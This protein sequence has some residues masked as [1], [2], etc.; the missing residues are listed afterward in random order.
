MSLKSIHL[1]NAWHANSGGIRT[2]YLALLEAAARR[3]HFMRMIVPG[4]E[5]RVEDVSEYGR[6]YYLKTARAPLSPEY[7]MLY[8]PLYL[9]PKG[10]IPRILREERPD[11]IEINDK[12]TLP[13]LSGLIRI[14]KHP[15]IDWRP[16]MIGLSCERMDENMRAYLLKNRAAQAFTRLYMKWIYF[17]E[18]DHHIAVSNHTA[19]EL[20]EASR[21][22]K[23]QRGVWIGP[24]GVDFRLFSDARRTVAA[25]DTVTLL[26]AGRLAR[27]KNL[28]LLIEV[29]ERLP[30]NYRLRIAGAGD[31][32]DELAAAAEARVPGRVSFLG[33]IADRG[34][35]AELYANAD[36]FVHPNP[37]EPFGIAPLEAMAAG[38]PLVAPNSGGL[39]VYANSGNAWLQ[40][41]EAGAFADAI[42]SVQADPGAREAKVRAARETAAG[43][44]WESATDYFLSLYEELHA[45]TQGRKDTPTIPPLF[46]STMGD[47]WGREAPLGETDLG[48]G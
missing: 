13:Y 37:R 43:Y 14:G 31:G 1:T 33:Q 10:S 44:S 42:R 40:A 39:L 25:S 45:I 5:D 9:N 35:L 20:K 48:V 4:E 15:A 46:Y 28:P 6:I 32:K 22:H 16:T 26:Y 3:K 29:M 34:Q 11:L 12:Y 27:E 18:F 41:A 19:A 2:F 23:K 24:M 36:T 21:G 38:L 8:P 17:P 30:A 47:A 7:R